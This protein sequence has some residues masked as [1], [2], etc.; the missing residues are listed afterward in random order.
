LRIGE[1]APE[2]LAVGGAR[3]VDIIAVGWPTGR[4]ALE[5]N[6]LDGQTM[7]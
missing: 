5:T 3:V 4:S 1:P 6:N 2:I 7:W